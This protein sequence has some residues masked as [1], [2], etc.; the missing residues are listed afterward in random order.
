M[1]MGIMK[2]ECLDL[3]LSNKWLKTLLKRNKMD[4]LFLNNSRKM[5]INMKLKTFIKI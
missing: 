1:K 4:C 5:S 2:M 3:V